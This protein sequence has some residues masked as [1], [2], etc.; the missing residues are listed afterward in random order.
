MSWRKQYGDVVFLK[1]LGQPMIVIN[2]YDAAVELFEKR[3]MNYSDRPSSVM[4]NELQQ[5]DWMLS[6]LSYGEQLKTYRTPVQKFFESS[7]ILQYEDVQKKE[8]QKLLRSLLRSPENYLQHLKRSLASSIMMLTY[9]HEIDSFDDPFVSLARKS[10]DHMELALQQG[11][12]AVDVI[13]WLKYI[14]KWFPGAGFQ[15]IAE[16]G[17]KLSHDLRYLPY[18]FAKDKVLSGPSKRSFISE[19]LDERTNSCNK[20]TEDDE[21]I[22]SATTGICYVA[23]ASTTGSAIMFFLLAMT[24]HPDVQKRAQDEIDRVVGFARL[25][26]LSDRDQL[27][28]C[29]ALLKEVHRWCP[30][31]PLGVAHATK[32]ADTYD[33]YY[34][35]ARTIVIPNVWAMLM[36]SEEYPDPDVFRPERFLP[37]AGQPMPRD[38]TKVA[39][40]F[41]RRVCPGKA[42]GENTVRF[43][44]FLSLLTADFEL[45]DDQVFLVATQI[46][47]VFDISKARDKDGSIIE[48]VVEIHSDGVVRQVDAFKCSIKPRSSEALA[49]VQ[50]E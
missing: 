26:E 7:N 18:Y 15:S 13:P 40:G 10:S 9:G 24:L 17:V 47:S 23:G 12:F 22:I 19:Q 28:Y 2:S 48:P 21:A 5:W 37:E 11:V 34:I 16:T 35:P 29:V 14:P 36:D 25:P 1:T 31:L 20:L 43:S 30:I 44:L 4:I 46:L 27:P 6:N 41:G 42:L 39:F 3:F 32:E 49:L 8:I 33:G 38:P 45:C 50:M